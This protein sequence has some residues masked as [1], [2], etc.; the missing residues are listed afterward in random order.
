MSDRAISPDKFD[1]SGHW[2][3]ARPPAPFM[4]R[5]VIAVSDDVGGAAQ[6]NQKIY[7]RDLARVK[8]VAKVEIVGRTYPGWLNLTTFGILGLILIGLILLFSN[9]PILGVLSLAAGFLG[10][11]IF[12]DLAAHLGRDVTRVSTGGSGRNP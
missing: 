5:F 11:W 1:S 4:Q 10:I 12:G 3:L 7:W 2:Y 6:I 8:I 9:T